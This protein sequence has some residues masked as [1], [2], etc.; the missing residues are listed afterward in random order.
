L[1]VKF[2]VA[3]KNARLEAADETGL[4]ESAFPKECPFTPE[5][6]LDESFWPVE[7]INKSIG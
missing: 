5:E 7:V 4:N 6:C 1:K 2:E 3:Y